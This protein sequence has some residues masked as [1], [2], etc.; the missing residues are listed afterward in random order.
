MTFLEMALRQI[1][2]EMG[3]IYLPYHFEGEKW[4][5][6]EMEIVKTTLDL[7]CPERVEATFNNWRLWKTDRFA[8]SRATWESGSL[9]GDTVEELAQELESYYARPRPA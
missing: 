9:V 7:H 6:E 2:E 3:D 1:A 4:T 5:T 8:A